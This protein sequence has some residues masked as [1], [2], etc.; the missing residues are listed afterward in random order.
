[1]PRYTVRTLESQATEDRDH[2]KVSELINLLS[3]ANPDAEVYVETLDGNFS[4]EGVEE[5]LVKPLGQDEVHLLAI[6]GA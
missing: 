3:R 1:M 4:I 5:L 2:V 6:K